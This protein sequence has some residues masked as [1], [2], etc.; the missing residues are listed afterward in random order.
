[1]IVKLQTEHY[2]EFLSFKGGCTC[3][4]ES[5][6]VKKPHCWKSHALAQLSL[7]LLLLMISEHVR[8]LN[9]QFI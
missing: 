6:L 3:S 1:M 8:T 7:I 5:S 2:W 9:M 4:S